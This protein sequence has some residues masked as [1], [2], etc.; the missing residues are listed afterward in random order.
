MLSHEPGQ[1]WALS[2]G[3]MI[4]PPSL[5]V[6]SPWPWRQR[7][8]AYLIFFVYSL[9][10]Q[11]EVWIANHDHHVLELQTRDQGKGPRASGDSLSQ[12]KNK[13]KIEMGEGEGEREGGSRLA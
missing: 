10:F 13:I 3:N 8:P 1:G 5:V 12:A 7:N 2:S 9:R 4:S 11:Q 6:G